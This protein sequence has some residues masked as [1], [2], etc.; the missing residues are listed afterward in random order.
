MTIK[1]QAP[2]T[3]LRVLIDGAFGK[4]D[5]VIE[6]EGEALIG[7][8]RDNQFLLSEAMAWRD[9]ALS[10]LEM[11]D[12]PQGLVPREQVQDL[13]KELASRDKA[14]AEIS[15]LLILPKKSPVSSKR[16]NDSLE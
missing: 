9:Q 7:F 3:K 2:T 13:E 11:A 1:K 12:S 5:D 4:P 10:G 6:L 8:C 15:A 16:K 14:L